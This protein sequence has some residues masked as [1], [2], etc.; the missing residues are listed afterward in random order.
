[1]LC[2]NSSKDVLGRQRLLYREGFGE[3]RSQL[4]CPSSAGPYQMCLTSQIR[5][6]SCMCVENLRTRKHETA[7]RVRLFP[8]WVCWYI[9]A[10]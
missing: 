1:M 7:S 5:N 6:K 4:C 2:Q 3:A 10:V 9:F 8:S